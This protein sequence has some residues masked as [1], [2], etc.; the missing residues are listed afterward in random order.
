MLAGRNKLSAP[1]G[2]VRRFRGPVWVRSGHPFKN[3]RLEPTNV[4]AAESLSLRKLPDCRH[5]AE[6][7]GGPTDQPSDIMGGENLIPGR[8]GLIDPPGDRDALTYT[9]GRFYAALNRV[10]RHKRPFMWFRS[11]R[12]KLSRMAPSC[13]LRQQN[14]VRV[15]LKIQRNS[16][17]GRANASVG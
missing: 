10:C 12:V 11:F 3:V 7:P 1:D 9:D 16:Y 13:A 8:V 14:G 15:S 5:A 4:F 6:D 17:H 2:F